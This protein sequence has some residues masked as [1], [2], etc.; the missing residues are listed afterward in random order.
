MRIWKRMYREEEAVQTLGLADAAMNG[1][2]TQIMKL[3]RWRL[4]TLLGAILTTF[5]LAAFYVDVAA[6]FKFDVIEQ[7]Y[8]VLGVCTLLGTVIVFV[9]CIGWAKLRNSKVRAIMAA[10]VFAM[11]LFALLIGTPVDGINI[12]GPSAITMMLILPYSAL[13]LILLIMAAV[14]RR[15]VSTLGQ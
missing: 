4:L 15:T 2:D 9:G 12:H 5:G 13:A 3:R 6:H 7:H 10:A 8:T 11:P 14:G 1:M